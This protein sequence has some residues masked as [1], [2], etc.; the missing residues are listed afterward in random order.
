MQDDPLFT[1]KQLYSISQNGLFACKTI[2]N[3]SRNNES[4]CISANWAKTLSKIAWN[5]YQNKCFPASD[6][7][8]DR[9]LNKYVK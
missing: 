8:T 4:Y 5:R 7:D 9:M 6:N 1:V 2:I 3:L